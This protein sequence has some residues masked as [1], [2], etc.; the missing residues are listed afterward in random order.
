MSELSTKRR[1]K[2]KIAEALGP[3]DDEEAF[4]LAGEVKRLR[5]PRG[6]ADSAYRTCAKILRRAGGH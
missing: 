4:R 3:Q 6:M 1:V 5:K 2:A